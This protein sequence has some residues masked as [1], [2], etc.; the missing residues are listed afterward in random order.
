MRII[1]TRYFSYCKRFGLLQGTRLYW[2]SKLSAGKVEFK[3]PGIAASLVMRIGTSDRPTF[4]KIFVYGEYD[5]LLTAKPKFIIDAG[6]NVGYASV[7]FANQYP[8]AKIIAVEP[9]TENFNLLKQNTASYPNITCMQCGVWSRDTYLKIQNPHAQHWAFRVVETDSPKDSFLSV[10][11]T[12]L[13]REANVDRIDLLKIDVEGAELEIFGA[14]DCANWLDR[15]DVILIEL[16]ENL[17]PGCEDVFFRAIESQ[18][19][20]RSQVGEN[21]VLIRHPKLLSSS[22]DFI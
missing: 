14:A 11:L 22:K 12:S 7:L 4:E 19:F 10:T 20:D 9:E 16:H 2:L 3:L 8:D 5:V 15:T 6:V 17:Q 21:M 1:K 18:S 13:L